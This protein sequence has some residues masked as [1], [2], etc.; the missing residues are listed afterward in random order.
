MIYIYDILLNFTSGKLYDFFEWEKTDKL[1]HIKKIPLFKV[2]KGI[3]N[4]FIYKN[5]KVDNNFVSKIY[6]YT[7]CYTTK[8]VNK[9]PYAFLLTDGILALAIKTDKFG[10]VKYRSKLLID[11]EEEILCLSS[12]LSIVNFEYFEKDKIDEE[13][14]LTRN[15]IKIKDYLLKVID[16]TYRNKEFEKLKYLYKEYSNKAN[17]KIDKIYEELISSINNNLNNSHYNLYNLLQLAT[18]KN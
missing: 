1:E 2:E 12:K 6:N 3:I 4:K 10:N 16:K 9:I 7:E 5:L 14:F 8:K 11:E 17:D 13:T 15:E 18:N